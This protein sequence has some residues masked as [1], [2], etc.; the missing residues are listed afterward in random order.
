MLKN[1]QTSPNPKEKKPAK[2]QS[3]PSGG[4]GGFQV[5]RDAIKAP[6]KQ[7]REAVHQSLRS[8][9]KDSVVLRRL[10]W[11]PDQ[12]VK[13]SLK[14]NLVMALTLATGSVSLWE[15]MRESF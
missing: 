6:R 9:C 14:P 11:N 3:H 13:S 8:P 10:H 12:M 15:A 4:I 1:C 7:V 5:S 2:F